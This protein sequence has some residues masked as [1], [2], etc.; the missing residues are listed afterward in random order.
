MYLY[1]L[2]LF[3]FIIFFISFCLFIDGYY[4]LSVLNKFW[5]TPNSPVFY[6]TNMDWCK[7]LRDNH[8]KITDEFLNYQKSYNLPVYG[9]ISSE[10]STLSNNQ[11]SKWRVAILKMYGKETDVS[12]H[13]PFTSSIINKIS[14]CYV[15][16]F[17]VLEPHKII[18]PHTGVNMS[19]LRYHLG[20]IIPQKKEMCTITINNE[21]KFWERGK[22]IIFDDTYMHMVHNNTDEQR[23]VLFLDIP[24]KFENPIV[25]IFNDLFF[26]IGQFNT[27]V[28]NIKKNINKYNS[29]KNHTTD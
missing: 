16:M 12:K 1:I 17:S 26:Y 9:N 4:I 29:L 25:N 14:K 19:V 21:T 10:Q 18:P 28:F 27:T 8:E 24:K 13:F 22:D 20:L 2:V 6:D 23:V 7:E 3:I 15:C 11:P 5:K